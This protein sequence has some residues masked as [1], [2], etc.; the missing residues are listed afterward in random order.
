MEFC[1]R[2]IMAITSAFQADDVGSIPIGRSM[3]D[4]ASIERP[5]EI[6]SLPGRRL[7]FAGFGRNTRDLVRLPTLSC[8]ATHL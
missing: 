1:D 8:D 6:G 7:A 5:M 3:L 4:A 2:R